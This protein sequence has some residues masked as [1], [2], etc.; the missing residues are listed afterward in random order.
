MP[1][2]LRPGRGSG[3]SQDWREGTCTQARILFRRE[4]SG[5]GLWGVRTT[6]EG[7]GKGQG[8]AHPSRA[9]SPRPTAPGRVTADQGLIGRLSRGL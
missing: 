2:I 5:A 3:V 1:N 7:A 6:L 9:D 4:R 8:R